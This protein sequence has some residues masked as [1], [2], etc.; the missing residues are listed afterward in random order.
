MFLLR[1]RRGFSDMLT[2][3]EVKKEKQRWQRWRIDLG[4]PSQ[5]YQVDSALGIS[6]FANA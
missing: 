1:P 2:E 3:E 6:R 5:I 4:L